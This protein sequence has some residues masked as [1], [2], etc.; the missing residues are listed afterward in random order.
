[1]GE[2]AHFCVLYFLLC[3]ISQNCELSAYFSYYPCQKIINLVC[4]YLL[5]NIYRL[6]TRKT[7]V[8]MDVPSS[9]DIMI[10]GGNSHAEL[11]SLI[12]R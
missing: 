9:S 6:C 5:K 11:V 2:F 12:A 10:I 3:N 1:M 8:N 7:A 4:D